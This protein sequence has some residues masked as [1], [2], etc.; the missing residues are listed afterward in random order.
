MGPI[1]KI[2]R[3]LFTFF[4]ISITSI[5][6]SVTAASKKPVLSPG[7]IAYETIQV[8]NTM[9]KHAFYHSKGKHLDELKDIWVKEDGEFAKTA[10]FSNPMMIVQGFQNVKRV[11]GTD[12]L[13]TQKKKLEA[14]SKIYPEIKNVPENIG[15]GYEWAMH[16]QTTPIIEIAGDGKTAKGVWYSP[17]VGLDG[18]ISNGEV[19]IF[20]TFFWEAY[21]V[22]FVKEDGKWKIWHIQ[23]YYDW[24][25]TFP[26]SM[27][28]KLGP[29]PNAGVA[30]AKTS[31]A[32]A[33]EALVEAA[34]KPQ[35]K[36]G[37]GSVKNPVSYQS[38]STTRKPEMLPRFPEPYYSFSETFSY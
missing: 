13:E 37:E 25:P 1:M 24:T 8:Q 31:V 36:M 22:D 33:G 3:I 27:T 32:S 20:S 26:A 29:G 16:T 10:T 23:M 5:S 35:N 30:A 34:E 14:I 4:V 19:K 2:M 18:D 28:E 7:E 38:W 6:S 11:Y 17:G 21:G 9:S 15:I 12:N